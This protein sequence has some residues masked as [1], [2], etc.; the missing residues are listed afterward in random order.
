[1]N[2]A[3]T[4]LSD[5]WRAPSAALTALTACLLIGAVG[6][7]HA[8][9]PGGAPAI[10]VAYGDLNVDSVPGTQA[11]YARIVAAAR[12]VCAYREVDIRD[13]GALSRA[14]ACEARAISQAVHDVHSPALAA[15]SNARVRHG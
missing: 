15:L 7:T 10:K 3:N 4:K 2:T 12:E 9:T 8:A 1:M 11:L 6:T 5:N 13:L 14:Q